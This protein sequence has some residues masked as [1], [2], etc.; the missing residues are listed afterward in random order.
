MSASSRKILFVAI[1][2]EVIIIFTGLA[3]AWTQ[4]LAAFNSHGQIALAAS[5]AAFPIILAVLE[6]FKIPSGWSIITARWY[7]KPIA[8]LMLVAGMLATAETVTTAGSTWFR[9]LNFEIAEA[10]SEVRVLKSEAD[11]VTSGNELSEIQA[12]I[13]SKTEEISAVAGQRYNDLGREIEDLRNRRAEARAT[14]GRE[15]DEQTAN[16]NARLEL[17]GAAAR[18]AAASQRSM[19]T[20]INYVAGVLADFDANDAPEIERQIAS[21]EQER[22]R[23]AAQ[24]A[25]Q[26]QVL[27]EERKALEDEWLTAR[28]AR[29]NAEARAAQIAEEIATAERE[30]AR[31]TKDSLIHDIASK[32]FAVPSIEVTEEQAAIVTRYVIGIVAIGAALATGLAAVLAA[33]LENHRRTPAKERLLKAARRQRTATTTIARELNAS[34]AKVNEATRHLAQ[35]PERIVYRYLPVDRE[36]DVDFQDSEVIDLKEKIRAA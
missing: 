16:N 22:E 33:H 2:A 35:R 8:I 32:I 21:R 1:A 12:A 11:R 3:L 27:M 4:A 19:P 36:I 6:L 30:L 24:A 5:A 31:L 25:N 9:A 20:R 7:I 17:G 18:E 29:R 34:Q 10:Q 14:A 26:S 23:L 13:A 15:W 28:T